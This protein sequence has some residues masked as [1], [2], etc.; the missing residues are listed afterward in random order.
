MFYAEDNTATLLIK[1]VFPEDAGLFTCVAKNVAGYAT[2][3]AELIVEG[4][5]SDHGSEATLTSRRSLSRE[6]S[7][8]DI[9]EGIPPTF[10]A[11]TITKM[12]EEN[13]QFEVDV[14]LVAIPEPEI[15]WKRDGQV[16]KDSQR[17][18]IIRQKDVHA[19]RST[20]LIKGTT[21]E[22]AG[23]YEVFAKNRE[24]DARCFINLNITVSFN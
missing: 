18:R 15:I 24:G 21:K 20:I 12:S 8:C 2:T 6:S 10:A 3:S 7:V 13:S 23:V 22:D 14:R 1:E 11:K 17:I 16:I 9:M 19:Y 5:M 4:P